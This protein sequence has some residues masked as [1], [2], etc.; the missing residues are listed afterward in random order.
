MG[1]GVSI[2]SRPLQTQRATGTLTGKTHKGEN[3]LFSIQQKRIPGIEK[4]VFREDPGMLKVA[5]SDLK[6]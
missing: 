5:E 1:K 3:A 6:A 2:S 4:A